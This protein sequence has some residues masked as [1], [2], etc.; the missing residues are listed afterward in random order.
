MCIKDCKTNPN[1]FYTVWISKNI[2][3]VQY[4]YTIMKRKH[5]CRKYIF[6][7]IYIFI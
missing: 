4:N 3:I 5:I 6:G 1:Y 2:V 7:K